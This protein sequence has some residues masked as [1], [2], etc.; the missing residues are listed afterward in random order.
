VDI[1][2]APKSIGNLA[3]NALVIKKLIVDLCFFRLTLTIPKFFDDFGVVMKDI[4]YLQ[5]F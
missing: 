3:L 1:F 4:I 2:I 5:Y